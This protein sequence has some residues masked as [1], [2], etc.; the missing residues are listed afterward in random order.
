[1]AVVA[2]AI[3]GAFFVVVATL[4]ATSGSATADLG[5]ALPTAATVGRNLE[6]DVGYDNT[7]NGVIN[8]TCILVAVQGPLQVSSVTFQGLDVER[9]VGGKACGGSLNGQETISVRIVLV[10]TRAGTATLSL[11]P[12]NGSTALGAGLSGR[13]AI[14][15][16]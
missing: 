4:F 10:P 16:S 2:I 12:A 3:M 7:G 15:A 14:A 11:T 13:I 5:G 8:S 1:M 9:V 6:V